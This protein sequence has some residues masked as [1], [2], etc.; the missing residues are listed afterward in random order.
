MLLASCASIQVGAALAT[1]TFPAVGAAGAAGWRFALAAVFLGVIARPRVSHWTA[2]R[3]RIVL[4]FGLAAAANELC[5]YFALARLPLGMAVTLEFLG[6]LG[7]ALASARRRSQIGVAAL[8]LAGVVAL[9]GSTMSSDVVGILLALAAALG[10]AAYILCSARAGTFERPLD[11]LA[12]AVAVAALATAPLTIAHSTAATTVAT[13]GSLALVAML[14][15]VLPYALELAALRRLAA[16]T[17][18]I[19]FSV[20]P[21]IAGV[22][23]LV[24]LGQ[25]LSPLQ[26]V[27][28]AAVVLAG[29][30][31]LRQAAH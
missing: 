30:L 31:A 17:V 28:I 1:S 8:A 20:E 18:G 11:G 27:G 10:W 5:L 21:A 4:A 12:V 24:G 3:W 2:Q 9:T 26:A 7:L 25:H 6:P 23:G 29:A 15:T 19:L 14:G 16:G 22:V 13:L